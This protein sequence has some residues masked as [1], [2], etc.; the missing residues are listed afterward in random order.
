MKDVYARLLNEV[1]GAEGG[2]WS[3]EERQS[4]QGRQ[5]PHATVPQTVIDRCQH[6]CRPLSM[7]CRE[8]EREGGRAGGREG[9]RVRE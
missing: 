4:I 9:G 1:Q 7:S 6:R 5:A 8:R 3:R 2:H